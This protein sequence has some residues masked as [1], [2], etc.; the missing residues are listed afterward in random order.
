MPREE[1]GRG[2]ENDH[3]ARLAHALYPA[4]APG[5]GG[6]RR[7]GGKKKK[8]AFF[9]SWTALQPR[10][11]PSREEKGRKGKGRREKGEKRLQ[12]HCIP[13][14]NRRLLVAKAGEGKGKKTSRPPH[15]Y[16]P[17]WHAMRKKKKEK[18]EREKKSRKRPHPLS[19]L[20]SLRLALRKKGRKKR[21]EKGKKDDHEQ[22]SATI[23]ASHI[24]SIFNP[25]KGGRKGEG[26]GKKVC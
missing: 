19:P 26:K 9:P 17:S 1:G 2:E 5:G 13:S 21:R 20:T 24:L 14:L 25:H 11:H 22:R 3:T 12:H 4:A 23:F 15:P 6:G 16:L 7:G 8:K 10:L 18:G